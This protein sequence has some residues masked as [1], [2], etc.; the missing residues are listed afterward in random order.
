MADTQQTHDP[1]AP[2]P[3]YKNKSGAMVRAALLAAM[4]AGAACG[5]I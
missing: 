3:R 1:Y 2:P 5:A 4:L